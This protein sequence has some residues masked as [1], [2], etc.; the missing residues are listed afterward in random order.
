LNCQLR[1]FTT[2]LYGNKRVGVDYAR[3]VAEAGCS[4][5][6]V[7]RRQHIGGNCYSQ[8]IDGVD[9]HCYGPH[10]FHTDNLRV[11]RFVNR[12]ARFNQYRHR[13]VVR[14]GFRLFSFP[15]NLLTL[16]QLWGVTTPQEA[17]LLLASKR[18]TIERPR[19]LEEWALSQ[20]GRELYEWFIRGYTIK[21]WGRDPRELPTAI[22]RRIPFRLTWD[23][24]YFDDRY[25]GIPI[26]GYT[27]LF[28]N[29]LDHPLIE[30]ET[31]VDFFAH[32]EELE[33]LGQ[34]LVYSGM[35]D[36]FFDY[37]FGALEYRSLRFETERLPGDFQGTAI[38]NYADL[39]HPYTRIVEHKHFALQKCAHT[40]I[41]REYPQA[42]QPGAE[43]FY[44]IGD[45]QNTARLEQYRKLAASEAPRVVF[46]G[47]LGSYQY[48]DMHQVIAQALHEA[49]RIIP[50]KVVKRKQA[51]R[52]FVPSSNLPIARPKLS[53]K[54]LVP[55]PAP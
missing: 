30:V 34:R 39:Q 31:Q 42:Y 19:N 27:R 49:D 3:R 12:F 18:E 46:G 37:R 33:S 40:V 26:D 9:V 36:E 25:Q 48:F 50:P 29:L 2:L 21:Q 38:V 28:E 5:L 14:S 22:L 24:S 7:D 16:Q 4:V 54:Q 13:G 45:P 6:L 17:Q 15:I 32:R 53:R 23:D 11:W 10:I 35:I 20:V 1:C 52:R 44:P 8:R 43:A 55:I 47:R 51:R 41:S